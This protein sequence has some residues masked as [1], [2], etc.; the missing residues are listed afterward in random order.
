MYPF[1]GGHHSAASNAMRFN[2]ITVDGI[3]ISY[4]EAGSPSD[5]TLLLLHGFPSSLNQF[6]NII[7]LLSSDYHVV[8]P[9]YPGYGTSDSPASFKYTFASLTTVIAGFLSALSITSY[10]PYI[11]DYGAPIALRLMLEHPGA[12]KA[13]ISQNGN[14][15]VEGFG[16]DFWAPIFRMWNT[17]DSTEAREA[18]R[19]GILTLETTAAQYTTGVPEQDLPLI[20]PNAYT[21]DFYQ[22]MYGTAAQDRQLDLLYDYRTNVP[23]YPAFHAYFRKTQIALLAVWGKGDPAFIPP[24]ATAYK[25]DLPMAQVEFVDSGHFALETKGE[26]IVA[27]MKKFLREIG[28][29]KGRCG[30]KGMV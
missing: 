12:T 8:A 9:S 4:V 2:N 24:G 29:C 15:Y 14:A 17:S 13:I 25:K 21:L 20:D 5:P 22:S 28:Y 26:V 11:F 3:T 7:P 1:F 27:R 30:K 19:A 23:L 10:V 6:R 16:Q 18:A